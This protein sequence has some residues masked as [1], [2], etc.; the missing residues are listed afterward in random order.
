ML[1]NKNLLLTHILNQ[2]LILWWLSSLVEFEIPHSQDYI[3]EKY[4]I[5][6]MTSFILPNSILLWNGSY[7]FFVSINVVL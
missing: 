6:R 7:F 1:E 2:I 4:H 5:K 3:K